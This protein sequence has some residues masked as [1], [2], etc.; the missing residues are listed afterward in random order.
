LSTPNT[1]PSTT[2]NQP[3]SAITNN[4]NLISSNPQSTSHSTFTT[5]KGSSNMLVHIEGAD[6]DS[7]STVFPHL[8]ASALKKIAAQHRN[9]AQRQEENPLDELNRGPEFSTYFQLNTDA[10]IEKQWQKLPKLNQLRS[11]GITSSHSNLV[12][13]GTIYD[14]SGQAALP[15]PPSSRSGLSSTL[16]P[17]PRSSEIQPHPSNLVLKALKTEAVHAQN[18][19]HSANNTGESKDGSTL[20]QGTS[21]H[22]EGPVPGLE[23]DRAMNI[24]HGKPMLSDYYWSADGQLRRGNTP[25]EYFEFKQH[26][27]SAT[28]RS[29][30]RN[31][32][33]YDAEDP[34]RPD[35]CDILYRKQQA[36][37]VHIVTK[38]KTQGAGSRKSPKLNCPEY[39][40][41]VV[42]VY[43]R[44]P[45]KKGQKNSNLGSSSSHLLQHFS[46]ESEIIISF[47]CPN[48]KQSYQIALK[49]SHHCAVLE[50]A[51]SLAQEIGNFA[52]FHEYNS[53][54]LWE[55]GLNLLGNKEK[56]GGLCAQLSELQFFEQQ[57][58]T[59]LATIDASG[60]I[61]NEPIQINNIGCRIL[62]QNDNNTELSSVDKV[63]VEYAYFRWSYS[64]LLSAGLLLSGAMDRLDML[65]NP[66]FCINYW[67]TQREQSKIQGIYSNLGESVVELS[68]AMTEDRKSLAE[69][70]SAIK[71]NAWDNLSS[72]KALFDEN[73]KTKQLAAVNELLEKNLQPYSVP[74]AAAAEPREKAFHQPIFPLSSAP[75]SRV[76][77]N[78]GGSNVLKISI[79]D[80]SA[81]SFKLSSPTRSVKFHPNA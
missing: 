34:Q 48:N 23:L 53:S 31:Y 65:F 49:S 10:A 16:S 60:V 26:H 52:Q 4:S 25:R 54:F 70:D 42:S 66:E 27:S 29:P 8:P 72:Q 17:S 63:S 19:F 7:L 57:N 2:L 38:G 28:N 61:L 79:E 12:N 80:S 45:N 58:H 44:I 22:A 47:Y 50:L 6:V 67:L 13:V 14:K 78:T 74:L 33:R 1:R 11:A 77:S 21:L 62:A 36:I 69:L 37:P 20:A 39:L 81:T 41:G 3:N 30:R 9:Q 73:N 32:H 75:L 68:A 35:N 40:T 18:I 55:S 51:A 24:L 15:Q 71:T 76:N 5:P 43:H 64:R 46:P 56:Y 59:V